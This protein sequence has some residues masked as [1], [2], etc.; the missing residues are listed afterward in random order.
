MPI[1]GD[2]IKTTI[3]QELD[4]VQMSN[5]MYWQIDALG[6]DPSTADGL[7]D[8]VNEYHDNIRNSCFSGWSVVCGIYDNLT[9]PEGKAIVFVNLPG[10]VGTDAHPQDQV[11]RLNSYGG[12][13][14]AN[15]VH[16]NWFNQSGLQEGLSTDGR[17]NDPANLDNLLDFLTAQQIM[18]GPSWTIDPQVRWQTA[19]G[20]PAVYAFANVNTSQW[21]DR[22]FKLQSRKTKLC[23]VQ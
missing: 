5:D 17:L 22:F 15:P 20:P 3:L 9:N 13:G 1:V 4:G 16:R 19:P 21:S 18:P 14:G 2:I 23:T 8:I 12:L 11:L 6:D 10:L 7:L